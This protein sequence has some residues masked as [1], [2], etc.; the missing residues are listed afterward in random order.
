MAGGDKHIERQ[1]HPATFNASANNGRSNKQIAAAL[2]MSLSTVEA[3]LSHAYRKLGVRRAGLAAR[4]DG[5]SDTAINPV[6]TAT[7]T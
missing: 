4:L 5:P 1:R 2:Y 3:H 7:Q 6:D